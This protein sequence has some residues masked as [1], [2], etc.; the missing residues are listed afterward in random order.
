MLIFYI[1]SSLGNED[2][3]VELE[4]NANEEWCERCKMKHG[5]VID[6]TIGIINII[7]VGQ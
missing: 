5:I 4:K 7:F 2:P 1:I 6:S 3:K